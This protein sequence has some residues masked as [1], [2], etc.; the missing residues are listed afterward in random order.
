LMARFAAAQERG[1]ARRDLTSLDLTNV[2]LPGVYGLLQMKLDAPRA[3]LRQALRRV[4]D[5]FVRGIAP[6]RR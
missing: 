5:V 3:E 2:F 4:V 1:E 6:T